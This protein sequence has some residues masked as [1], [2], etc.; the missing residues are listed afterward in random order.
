MGHAIV[1]L[2]A[3]YTIVS[4][5]HPTAVISPAAMIGR[6]VTIGPFAVIEDGVVIGD[7]CRL[8][9]HVVVRNGT[10]LGASDEIAEFTVI[11][12]FPQHVKRPTNPGQL[13]LGDHNKIHEQVTIHRSLDQNK[14]TTIG[15]HN[16]IMVGAH[17]GHDCAVGDHT[18]IV[19]NVLLA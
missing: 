15:H 13:V 10:I 5:I 19:N 14:S 6:D 3:S 1:F 4:A 2:F 11:G 17:I 8:A 18:T 9:S 7:G 16:L 12:G